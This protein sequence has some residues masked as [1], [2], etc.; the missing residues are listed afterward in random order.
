MKVSIYEQMAAYYA[1]IHRGDWVA[2]RAAF[3]AMMDEATRRWPACSVG[4]KKWY[5]VFA[6]TSYESTRD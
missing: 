2:R 1:A 4:Y 5:V 3:D 6:A